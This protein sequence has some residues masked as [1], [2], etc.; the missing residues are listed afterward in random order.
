MRPPEEAPVLRLRE[1]SDCTGGPPKHWPADPALG[2]LLD[3]ADWSDLLAE[4]PGWAWSKSDAGLLCPEH[5]VLRAVSVRAGAPAADRLGVIFRR[6]AG[7]CEHCDTRPHCFQTV[8]ARGGKQ[9]ELMLP[10]KIATGVAKRLARMHEVERRHRQRPSDDGP[11]AVTPPMMLPAEAR[12][13]HLERF[14]GATL[15]VTVELPEQR[16]GRPRLIAVDQ[17]FVQRRRKTWGQRVEDY[18]LPEGAR[19]RVRV[20]GTRELRNFLGERSS[21]QRT[22][23]EAQ[24]N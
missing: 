17:R 2:R 7:G 14:V 12:A 24:K 6:P 3:K 4:R 16:P 20:Q 18:A 8:L 22:G 1:Q 10:A 13:A 5:R 11:L 9:V 19:V 23:A 21:S 15:H